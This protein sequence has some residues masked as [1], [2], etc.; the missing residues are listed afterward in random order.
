MERREGG[1]EGG[2]KGGREGEKEGRWKEGGRE[3]GD[4]GYTVLCTW[5]A[6]TMRHVNCSEFGY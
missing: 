6:L 1:R 4:K 3:E 2:W 5:F